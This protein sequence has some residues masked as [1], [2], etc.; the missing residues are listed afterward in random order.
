M[1]AAAISA[2]APLAMVGLNPARDFGPRLFAA[3]AGWGRVATPGPQDGFFTVYI[4]APCLGAL[5]YEFALGRANAAEEAQQEREWNRPASSSSGAFSAPARP[6]CSPRRPNG[7]P[8]ATCR[9]G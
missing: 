1:D 9:S 3:C 7:S 6:R 2:V 8:F 5:V 4:L